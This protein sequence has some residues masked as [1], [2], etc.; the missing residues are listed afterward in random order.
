MS[1]DHDHCRCSLLG[2]SWGTV[3]RRHVP[4][5]LPSQTTVA[6][7]RLERPHG[8]RSDRDEKD[9]ESPGSQCVSLHLL[10]TFTQANH[11]V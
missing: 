5:N 6:W 3:N 10:P 1:S 4:G 9:D 7:L 2:W 11:S 8:G